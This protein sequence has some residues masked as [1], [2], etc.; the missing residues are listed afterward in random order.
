MD[1]ND[2]LWTMYDYDEYDSP[3]SVV[4]SNGSNTSYT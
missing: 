4:Q 1:Q 2:P 3:L